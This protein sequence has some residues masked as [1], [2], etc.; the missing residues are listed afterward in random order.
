M[1]ENTRFVALILVF[2]LLV[3]GV[4][5]WQSGDAPSNPADPPR[6]PTRVSTSD[7]EPFDEVPEAPFPSTAAPEPTSSASENSSTP[8]PEEGL[9]SSRNR[10]RRPESSRRNVGVI[11]GQVT[12]GD[13][14]SIPDDLRVHILHM[15]WKKHETPKDDGLAKSARIDADG[16][17]EFT[18]LPFGRYAISA[19]G[20]GA[21]RASSTNLTRQNPSFNVTLKL[22]PAGSVSGVVRDGSGSAIEGAHV[23]VAGTSSNGSERDLSNERAALSKTATD[24]DGRWQLN[25][26]F[27]KEDFTL[28]YRF[29]ASAPGYT[30]AI[31]EFVTTGSTDVDFTLSAGGSVSGEV[32][33]AST[34]EPVPNIAVTVGSKH[35]LDRKHTNTDADG[36]F[37]MAALRPGSHDLHVVDSAFVAEAGAAQ[38]NITDG[39]ETTGIRVEVELGGSVAGR[40]YDKDTEVGI[41]GTRISFSSEDYEGFGD[42]YEMTGSGGNYRISALPEGTYQIRQRAPDEYPRS[43]SRS[44]EM[45]T[46][47]V[48]MG[49]ETTGVDFALSQGL[50]ITGIVEDPSGNPMPDVGLT[51]QS[52]NGGAWG[53]ATSRDDGSF[54]IAGLTPA[55]DYMITARS[56]GYAAAPV[57]PIELV[58]GSVGGVRVLLEEEGSIEGV[59]VDSTGTPVQH[60]GLYASSQATGIGGSSAQ[61]TTSDGAFRIGGL[62][63]GS[64][65]FQAMAPGNDSSYSMLPNNPSVN[66][67]AGQATTGV[68]VVFTRTSGIVISGRVLNEQGQPIHRAQIQAQGPGWGHGNSQQDGSF[69]ISGLQEGDYT[70]NV[71]HH[72]FSGAKIP[73][74]APSSNIGIEL[75]DRGTVTGT[76]LDARTQEPISDFS[77]LGVSG[78]QGFQG[79]MNQNFLSF[80]SPEGLFELEDIE[81]GPA[82]I[83]V[84]AEGYA[85]QSHPI[86]FVGAGET[87]ANIVI[88]LEPGTTLQGVV[89]NRAGE[90]IR[91]AMLFD[92]PVPRNGRDQSAKD[93]TEANGTFTLNSMPIGN[94]VIGVYHP[95]YA[96]VNIELTLS[97]GGPNHEEIVLAEGGTVEGYVTSGG[98]PMPN[99]YVNISSGANFHQNVQTDSDGYFQVNGLND[100]TVNVSTNIQ[101]GGNS[102]HR[103]TQAEVVDGA[104]TRVDFDFTAGNST[105]E[106]TLLRD[107]IGVSGARIG[108]SIDTGVGT[109]TFSSQTDANGQFYFSDLPGGTA[110]LRGNIAG[111]N[112]NFR[113]ITFE[114]PENSAVQRDIDMSGGSTLIVT[115]DGL[116][117]SA[118]QIVVYALTGEMAIPE[119]TQAFFQG[120]QSLLAGAAMAVGNTAELEGIAPGTYTILGMAMNQEA[121]SNGGDPF[122]NVQVAST[123]ITI[124][125]DGQALNVQLS[126]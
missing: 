85:P 100:G 12:A 78:N 122:A 89:V 29:G 96:P 43:V 73:V 105:V 33:N 74:S 17:F 10:K 81:E 57:G 108:L 16:K 26:L 24:S 32:V 62:A 79:Y 31:S 109:E 93:Y 30:T 41:S 111:F 14:G 83:M 113:H 104:V 5:W 15:T 102:Q 65:T 77:L 40:V 19:E 69:S 42:N 49:E 52:R 11:R 91:G 45:K 58:D 34:G 35:P 1:N 68:R 106:G 48:I 37:Q 4:W 82:T 38:F 46:V 59:V 47:T 56:D 120:I 99:S 60:V 20:T 84:R 27:I 71:S 119:P 97:T 124:E 117:S 13:A 50:L 118:T 6:E 61:R 103:T 64:Y 126:F 112:N 2:C 107:G 8:E 116:S 66:V 70:L 54:S 75:R 123:V 115:M 121:V 9:Q 51:T 3:A 114:L 23:F 7:T 88:S 87:V 36:Q 86:D 98:Q 53:R 95:H 67:T 18:K 44:N 90:P 55:T 125:S 92:G 72:Q 94:V 101:N 25:T 21:F 22:Q 80:R 39:Q 63:T 110:T 28:T 76:I